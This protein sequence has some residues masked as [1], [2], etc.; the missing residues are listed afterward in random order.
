MQALANTP[1]LKY[2]ERS[3]EVMHV[4]CNFYFPLLG[5]TE[6][7]DWSE[8]RMSYLLYK[9]GRY[10][11]ACLTVTGAW[12]VCLPEITVL[13]ASCVSNCVWF[14]LHK[15]KITAIM[16]LTDTSVGVINSLFTFTCLMDW[17]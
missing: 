14:H 16:H 3:G 6:S 5:N 10:F 2:V 17:H 11:S 4:S 9:M 8:W 12:R 1:A 7:A 15:S 13:Y